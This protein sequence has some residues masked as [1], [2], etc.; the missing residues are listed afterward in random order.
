[1]KR[2][3]TGLKKEKR[4]DFLFNFYIV[5]F[6]EEKD[7]RLVSDINFTSSSLNFQATSKPCKR[8][9]NK[10]RTAMKVR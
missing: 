4:T 9:K 10:N 1:M 7:A 6:G 3:Q 8:A 5:H 2:R